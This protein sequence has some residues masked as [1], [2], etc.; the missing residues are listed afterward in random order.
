MG[1]EDFLLP[2]QQKLHGN[3]NHKK[4]KERND[5][6]KAGGRK[7]GLEMGY[8]SVK[9]KSF[10]GDCYCKTLLEQVLPCQRRERLGRP[11]L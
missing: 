11:Q 10:S 8:L 9:G 6:R 3:K 5:R 2:Q 4:K 1:K 7:M